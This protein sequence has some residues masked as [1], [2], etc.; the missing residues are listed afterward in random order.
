MKDEDEEIS[1]KLNKTSDNSCACIYYIYVLMCFFPR[2]VF[3]QLNTVYLTDPFTYLD[4]SIS[5]FLLILT[6]SLSFQEL[7]FS[8]ESMNFDFPF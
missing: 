3:A 6:V 1:Q 2:V 7:T 4:L 5:Q 8:T